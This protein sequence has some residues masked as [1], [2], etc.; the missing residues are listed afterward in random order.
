MLTPKN[1]SAY[2]T[3]MASAWRT[4]SSGMRRD[5]HSTS[6]RMRRTETI[7]MSS[8]KAVVVLMPPAVD[9]GAPPVII[10]RTMMQRLPSLK[11]S[12]SIVLNPAVRVV[13]DWKSACQPLIGSCVKKTSAGTA[14]RTT[15]IMRMMRVWNV[16]RRQCSRLTERSAQV[17]KP[18]PPA[19]MSPMIVRLTSG[20][21]A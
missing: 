10:K 3:K 20:S 16:S 11:S 15:V 7:A 5:W 2:I 18:R 4:V 9:P 8:A 1:R 14:T 13:T 12:M 21:P 6:P 17:K 19:M